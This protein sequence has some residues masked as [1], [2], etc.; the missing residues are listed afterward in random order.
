VAQRVREQCGRQQPSQADAMS[1]ATDAEGIEPDQAGIAGECQRQGQ[2]QIADRQR[3]QRVSKL[4]I[5]FS[6]EFA[7]ECPQGQ[8]QRDQA[9]DRDPALPSSRYLCCQ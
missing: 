2:Q 1:A 8:P 6:A 7:M 3:A 9:A 5:A 4:Y